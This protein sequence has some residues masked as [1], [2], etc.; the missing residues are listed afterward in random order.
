MPPP[1]QT[2]W[3]EP[4]Q[5]NDRNLADEERLNS[6]KGLFESFLKKEQP[7][8]EQLRQTEI[9]IKELKCYQFSIGLLIEQLEEIVKR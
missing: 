2:V 7:D 6:I 1:P 3:N 4:G 8:P 5:R 9:F